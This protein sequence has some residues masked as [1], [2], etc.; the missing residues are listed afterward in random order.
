MAEERKRGFGEFE[1]RVQELEEQEAKK[2]RSASGAEGE[3]RQ[4]E[5]ERKEPRKK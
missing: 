5:T 2:E 3:N 4:P 1:K